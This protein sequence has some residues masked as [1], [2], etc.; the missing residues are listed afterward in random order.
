MNAT[1]TS[2][3]TEFPLSIPAAALSSIDTVHPATH[4][5]VKLITE[6]LTELKEY[7]LGRARAL[8]RTSAQLSH[9]GGL[10]VGVAS[11]IIERTITELR[12]HRAIRHALDA[13]QDKHEVPDGRYAVRGE[14]GVVRFYRL[15]TR[16]NGKG[17]G[18]QNIYVY[19]SDEQHQVPLKA[20]GAIRKQILSAGI[21]NAAKLFGTELGH[22]YRCGRSL[23]D[24]TSRSL[25]IGPECI[26]K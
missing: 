18:Y 12:E 21:D 10:S 23:T 14:D 24:E 8:W 25:G 13:A 26:K 15:A 17:K 6:L 11:F 1:I 7:E 19:A 22:C 3:L 9:E 2:T 20:H 16:K 5:Q 4:S